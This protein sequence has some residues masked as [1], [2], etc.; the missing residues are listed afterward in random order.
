MKK[1][2][3][4]PAFRAARSKAASRTMK[5][6][7]ATPGFVDRQLMAA[8][9]NWSRPEYRLKQQRA[10]IAGQRP[11]PLADQPPGEPCPEQQCQRKGPHSYHVGIQG[12]LTNADLTLVGW[13][14][15][16]PEP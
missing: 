15:T 14:T 8:V 11:M 10:I 9:K 12:T 6:L 4:D 16:K 3:Q 5:T 1:Q 7:W 2:W 13:M